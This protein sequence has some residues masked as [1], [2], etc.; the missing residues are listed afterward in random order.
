MTSVDDVRVLVVEDDALLRMAITRM[1]AQDG[2]DCDA[3][4]DGVE[5]LE[6]VRANHYA[7]IITDMRMPRM[8]GAELIRSV[9]ELGR[10]TPFLV[11]SGYHDSV[12]ELAMG[13]V[14]RMLTKPV[15]PTILRKVVAEVLAS[16]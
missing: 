1:L 14:V 12:V 2:I 11:L 4:A 8:S 5:G 10:S 13:R 3:A 7:L 9:G 15:H 16:P 6:R